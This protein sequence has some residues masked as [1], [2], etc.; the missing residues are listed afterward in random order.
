[1]TEPS[2]EERE[3][4]YDEHI[5]PKLLEISDLC[6]ENGMSMVC[7]VEWAPDEGGRT[8]VMQEDAGTGMKVAYFA[9]KA[10]SNVDAL[11]IAIERLSKKVGHNSFV[12]SMMGRKS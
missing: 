3:S 6:K 11:F 12:L 8:V 1:M 10:G 9:A 5:A 4:F 7:K 2:L